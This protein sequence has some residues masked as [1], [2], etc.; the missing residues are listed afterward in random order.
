VRIRVHVPQRQ[1]SRFLGLEA[2]LIAPPQVAEPYFGC[3][4]AISAQLSKRP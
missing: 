1:T 2:A 3:E 4:A